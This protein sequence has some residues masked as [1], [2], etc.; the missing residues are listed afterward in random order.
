MILTKLYCQFFFTK[1]TITKLVQIA[2]VYKAVLVGV[3]VSILCDD[4]FSGWYLSRC[5]T[6]GGPWCEIMS[7]M[8]SLINPLLVMA[9]VTH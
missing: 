8:I 5:N 3:T 2:W 4:F 6:A 1:I 9:G 7:S